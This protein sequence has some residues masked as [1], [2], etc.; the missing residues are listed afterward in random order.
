MLSNAP[1]YIVSQSMIAKTI[2]FSKQK[3]THVRAEK[4]R[5]LKKVFEEFRAYS[6]SVC[7]NRSNYLD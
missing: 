5:E 4:E 7:D 6:K 3:D 1:I 2:R